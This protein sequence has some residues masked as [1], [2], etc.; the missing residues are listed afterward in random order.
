MNDHPGISMHKMPVGANLGGA[1]F[2]LG[3]VVIVLLGIPIAKFF[4]LAAIVGGLAVMGLLRLIR[5]HTDPP[6]SIRR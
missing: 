5:R 1:I 3:A 4:L 6:I 2:M